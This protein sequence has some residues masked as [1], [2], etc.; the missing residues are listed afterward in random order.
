M[1]N[2]LGEDS[3][4]Q[5]DYTLAGRPFKHVIDRLDS[6]LMVMKSCKGKECHLPWQ[7]LHPNSKIK[8][9][10]HALD[11]DYDTFYEKQPK[12]SYTSCELGYLIDAEGPQHV[13]SWDELEHEDEPIVYQGP[14]GPKQ[15]SFKYSGPYA[16]WT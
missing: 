13:N 3:S 12:V 8:T 15:Q 7:T 10:K 6:L 4:L 9:L 16:W 11:Q 2:Y 1:V 14:N 5:S